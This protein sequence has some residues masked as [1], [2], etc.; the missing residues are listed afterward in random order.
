MHGRGVKVDR[1]YSVG[2]AKRSR[3]IVRRLGSRCAGMLKA[4]CID[5]LQQRLSGVFTDEG[6]LKSQVFQPRSTDVFV[7]GSARSGTTWLQQI[8]HQ[9]R[10]G[11]DVKFGEIGEVVPLLEFAHDLKQDLEAEQAP[12]HAVSRPTT[13]TPAVQRAPGTHLV[14]A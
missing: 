14:H 7:A 8:V 5:L 10:T 9:L 1:L 12:S 11:G 4:Q 3:E 2:E 6:H 13:G